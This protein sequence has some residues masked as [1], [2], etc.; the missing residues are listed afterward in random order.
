MKVALVCDSM[1]AY[2]G[3]E[4]VIE[5][6]LALYP[7]AD[8]FTVLDVVP[9]EQRGF[10]EG[11]KI[12]ASALQHLPYVERYYRALLH[13]WPLAV[14]QLDVTGYDLVISSHHSVAYGVLTRPGQVHVAYVHSPMRYAWDLQHDYLRNASL[15][16]GLGSLIARRTLHKV[17]MWDYT[18]AQRPDALAANSH[19]VAERIWKTH[20]RRAE[21]VP[22]PVALDGLT[23]AAEEGYYLSLGRLVPYKRVDLLVRA[24]ALMPQRR[25]KVVGEGPEMRRIAAQAGPNVELLGYQP[26]GEVRR[27]LARARAFLFAGVEDFGIAAVE[28]QAAGTPVIAFGQGGLLETVRG[29]GEPQPTGLFFDEQREEAIVAAVADFERLGGHFS[30]EA[31]VANAARFAP[32]CFRSAFSAFVEQVMLTR[33]QGGRSWSI[34]PLRT[35]R[36]E[37][38]RAAF[39]ALSGTP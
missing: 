29:L 22:P 8:L 7:N 35:G 36:A 23:P 37:E 30:A 3:A 34:P 10:L 21:V 13:F 12:H 25:L 24:F 4:R 6:L 20:R 39:T 31:C 15:E 1:S 32:D 38:P 2:G 5:Q 16:R 28:A 27:L 17:R 18:A 14:E 19:F 33:W 11:R 9:R 26:A